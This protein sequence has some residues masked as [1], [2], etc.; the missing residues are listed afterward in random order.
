MAYRGAVI[1]QDNTLHFS[2]NQLT[3]KKGFISGKT[4]QATIQALFET[5]FNR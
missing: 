1:E 3:K 4:K 5:R 2:K